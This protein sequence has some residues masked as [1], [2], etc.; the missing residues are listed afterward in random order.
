MRFAPDVLHLRCDDL[1]GGDVSGR[2]AALRDLASRALD[3]VHRHGFVVFGIGALRLDIDRSREIAGRLMAELR[4]AVVRAGGPREARLEQDKVQQTEVPGGYDTRTLLPHHDGQH[5]SYLTPSVLDDDGWLPAWREFGTSG[6]TT[7]PAHKMYQGVFVVDPGNGLSVTTYYDWVE[8]LSTVYAERVGADPAAVEPAAVARWL[9]GNLRAAL[10]SQSDHR[11]P[12]P[13]LGAML[14]VPGAVSARRTAHGW[15]PLR[16]L[17]R[18]HRSAV[19]PPDAHGHG[20][21]VAAMPGTMG[22]GGPFGAVRPVAG[23]QPDHAARRARRR[24]RPPAGTVLPG[25]R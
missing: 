16:R 22:G 8:I 23:S 1:V 12:Y 18:R 9:G 24:C 21:D 2:A 25:R 20:P 14:G 7:T 17:R 6:Y 11:C 15:V 13:S 5:C 19:L 3:L 4:E 10:G